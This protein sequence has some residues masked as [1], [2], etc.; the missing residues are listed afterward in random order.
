[1][2]PAGIVLSWADLTLA[3]CGP[4]LHAER[5]QIRPG[6]VEG[7]RMVARGFCGG[8]ESEECPESPE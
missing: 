7:Y 3:L 6:M 8:D 4:F 5:V 2:W 1:M